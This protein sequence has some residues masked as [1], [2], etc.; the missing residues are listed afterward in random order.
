VK[1][2]LVIDNE[3]SIRS[4]VRTFLERG[5]YEAITTASS[6]AEGIKIFQESGDFDLVWT[7]Y[8]MPPGMNGEQ[9][10]TE[11]KRLKPDQ[12]AV[13]YTA[14]QEILE[15]L[16]KVPGNFLFLKKP[17]N[18]SQVLAAAATAINR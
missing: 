7:D 5:G 16:E 1:R 6:G 17:A 3:E 15:R 9:V 12:P 4:I 14:N 10:I 2:I 11:V 8:E 13:L 18:M